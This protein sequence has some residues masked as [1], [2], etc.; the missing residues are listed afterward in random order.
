M[1]I[2]L[3]RE[4]RFSLVPQT[5]LSREFLPAMTSFLVGESEAGWIQVC[6][7]VK[8]FLLQTF[9]TSF[10]GFSHIVLGNRRAFFC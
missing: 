2:R 6:E 9:F 10:S 4:D 7:L 1:L 8:R 3:S 5:S